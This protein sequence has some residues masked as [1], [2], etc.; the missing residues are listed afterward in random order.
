MIEIFLKSL[1]IIFTVISTGLISN[2]YFFKL[3][4]NKNFS[5]LGLLGIIVLSI[6]SFLLHFLTP[7][8]T[9]IS[10]LI[11]IFPLILIFTE[12]FSQKKIIELSKY[13]LIFSI[14][15]VI[16]LSYSN[17]YRPD[18]GWYHLPF[19]RLVSDFK[20]IAGT[21]SLHPMFGTTAILQYLS[22]VFHNTILGVNGILFVNPVILVL[23]LVFFFNNLVK[24]SQPIL[25]FF[26]LVILFSIFVEMNRN[27][28]LGN[29]APGYLFYFYLIYS[30]I[31]SNLDASYK[32]ERFK[33]LSLISV[34]CFFIKSLYIF[35]LAIPLFIFVKERLYLKIYN[36]FNIASFVLIAWF[37]KNL[38][39][40]GCLIYP[41]NFTCSDKLSWYSSES[42]F[43]I[44]A[45][46]TSQFSELHSKGWPDFN[47]N[48]Q[49][50]LDYKDQLSDKNN[51][52][53]NFNWLDEYFNQGRI[54]NITKKIDF[55]IPVLILFLLT[56]FFKLKK[57]IRKNFIKLNR[58]L[59]K[60]NYKFLLYSSLAF[61]IIVLIKLP[62]AR[63]FF[64][65]LLVSIFLIIIYFIDTKFLFLKKKFSIPNI[66]LIIL[67]SIFLFKNSVKIIS[68]SEIVS[69]LPNLYSDK[70]IFDFRTKT[71]DDNNVF[72]IY[73]T[74]NSYSKFASEKLCTYHKSPCIQNR[75][76]LDQ[77]NIEKV[78][79]YFI[80]KLLKN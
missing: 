17:F 3:N 44:S 60:F 15:I 66:F 12:K 30:F 23:F 28:E 70:P 11:Y 67:F 5:E 7:L 68:H 42:K 14:L 39:I 45:K 38:I 32:N 13:C 57:N 2:R 34:F 72:N 6:I 8:N 73:Y 62:D 29:D 16:Y 40:T 58:G 36:Y 37:I 71:I 20:I 35:A 10:N 26:N 56:S 21:A 41:L 1:I 31:R 33:F 27:S 43:E 19:S 74:D 25:K 22:S 80:L 78:N 50:Y 69:P 59:S 51:F 47:E 55:L 24:E 9:L 75:S 52:L 48:K 4:I 54:Y 64:G 18:A 79:G 65:Y 46:N 76:I 61:T 63:Y 77:F 49:Y 53:K